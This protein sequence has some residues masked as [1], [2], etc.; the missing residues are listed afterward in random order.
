MNKVF[1]VLVMGMMVLGNVQG[2]A[3]WDPEM[4]WMDEDLSCLKE[5]NFVALKERVTNELKNSWC[6]Q[7]KVQLLM[8]L[9]RMEKPKVCVEIGAFTGSSVLP[10]AA[11]LA[12]SKQGTIYAIDAWSNDVMV[13]NLDENDPNRPW[14]STVDM[15]SVKQS[16]GHLMKKWSVQQFVHEIALPSNQAIHQIPE[17]IDFLHLDGDYS[18]QGSMQ[19]VEFYVSKVKQ[20]GY[21]LLSNLYIMINGKQPKL[22]A[23]CA[24]LETCDI[25]TEIENDN[26]IL[27]KK[28]I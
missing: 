7:E 3:V 14:W 26:A 22:K 25:V 24:L 27:F 13:K 17:G 16:F 1:Q 11:A 4:C 28:I 15:S 2:F 20:G 5:A 6:S 23:F 19:D 9:V 12:Y 18:E 21:I 10:V 8:D